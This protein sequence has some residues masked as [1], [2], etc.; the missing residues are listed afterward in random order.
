MTFI[1][2]ILL[3]ILFVLSEKVSAQ[4]DALNNT[5]WVYR[6]N[7]RKHYIHIGSQAGQS[8]SIAKIL[9]H[10]YCQNQNGSLIEFGDVMAMHGDYLAVLSSEYLLLR[11]EV[12]QDSLRLEAVKNELYFAINAVERLDLYGEVYFGKEASLNGFFVRDDVPAGFYRRW[13]TLGDPV[14]VQ[15]SNNSGGRAV[16]YLKTDSSGHKRY[17]AHDD[18]AIIEDLPVYDPCFMREGITG[19]SD[20]LKKSGRGNEMSQDQ[21]VGLL[22]G[23]KCV[24]T[25]TDSALTVDPD[26]AKG[27][28]RVCLLDFSQALRTGDDADDDDMGRAVLLYEIDRSRGRPARRYHRIDHYVQCIL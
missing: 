12:P 7:F 21:L 26:G 16:A 15:N 18:R 17:Y 6:E 14:F 10:K 27:P 5:Y 19:S 8:L 3:L 2:Y 20:I 4:T 22:F 28:L 9:P 24:L 11:S 23:F 1:R 13:E 25:F